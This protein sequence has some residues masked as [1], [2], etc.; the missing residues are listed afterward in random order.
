MQNL[1]TVAAASAL[2]GGMAMFLVDTSR[3]PQVYEARVAE[4]PARLPNFNARPIPK[5]HLAESSRAHET[6]LVSYKIGRAHV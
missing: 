1:K 5:R 6:E 4:A 3:S 2:V